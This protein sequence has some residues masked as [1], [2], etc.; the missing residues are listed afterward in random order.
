ME[1][2]D[3]HESSSK[4]SSASSLIAPEGTEGCADRRRNRTGN[5][6]AVY[7]P[8]SQTLDHH[9][10]LLPLNKHL[11]QLQTD[12]DP[13]PV[14]IALGGAGSPPAV[15]GGSITART[16]PTPKI[17]VTVRYRECLRNHAANIGSHVV[18]GCGEF[19]PSGDHGTPEALNCAACNCHRNFHWKEVEG[20]PRSSYYCYDPSHKNSCTRIHP[21]HH[22]PQLAPPHLQ[23]PQK[24]RLG[25]PTSPSMGSIPPPMM[26]TYGGGGGGAGATESSSEDL[27]VYKYNTGGSYSLPATTFAMSKKRFRTKFTHHQKDRMLEFAEKLGWRIQKQN[28]PDVQQF[29]EELGVK[30]QVLKVWM[31]NNKHSM[32]KKQS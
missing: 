3:Q 30:R 12:P 1:L 22:H 9:R 29:C 20:E 26:M 18:D 7:N 2:R 14:A 10:H 16:P 27:N 31:H 19:M 23:Q 4:V 21:S 15:P 8:S 5:G 28:E 25:L 6:T 11:Q 17:S 32:M 13:V 24:F